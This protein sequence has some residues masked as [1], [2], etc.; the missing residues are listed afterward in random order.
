MRRAAALL[1]AGAA[2]PAQSSD[3][4][5]TVRPLVPPACLLEELPR[6]A[7]HEEVVRKGREE[8][9][10]V[11]RGTSPRVALIVGQPAVDDAQACL[12]LASPPLPPPL[13]W[14]PLLPGRNPIQP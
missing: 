4:N 14:P 13:P 8:L 3:S 6:E 11:L 12:E 5:V 2:V 1:L 7:A 10:G 9:L